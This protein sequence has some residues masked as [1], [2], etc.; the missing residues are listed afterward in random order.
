MWVV[1]RTPGQRTTTRSGYP[2]TNPPRQGHMATWLWPMGAALQAMTWV[3]ATFAIHL[4][5]ASYWPL[6]PAKKTATT[7][8]SKI[9]VTLDVPK[10]SKTIN[11]SGNK[12]ISQSLSSKEELFV[13]GR[14]T[15][16]KHWSTTT[17]WWIPLRAEMY[18]CYLDWLRTMVDITVEFKGTVQSSCRCVIKLT[19]QL[20]LFPNKKKKCSTV[21][22]ISSSCCGVCLACLCFH[23][24]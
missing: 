9:Q 3:S 15:F 6:P 2:A 5:N 14:Q 10:V 20:V 17:A 21:R 19:G 23:S 1:C 12:I 22:M 18:S 4:D 11:C 24:T 7:Q 16:M 13:L 8:T